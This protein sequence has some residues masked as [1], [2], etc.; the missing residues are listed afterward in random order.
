MN[1]IRF[2]VKIYRLDVKNKP[3]LQALQKAIND[4]TN[5]ADKG[6]LLKRWRS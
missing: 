3:K 4:A 6:W 2:I 1:F 5:V